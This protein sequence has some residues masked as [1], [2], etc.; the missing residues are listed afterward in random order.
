MNG[1]YTVLAS[2]V[3]RVSG[4][5]LRAFAEANIFKPLGMTRTLVHDDPTTIVP[6]RVSGYHP[7]ERG[8]D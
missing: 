2:I 4:Q 8:G 7:D 6:N 3:K 5:S 1:G